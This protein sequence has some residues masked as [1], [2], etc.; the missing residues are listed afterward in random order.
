MCP[1]A[2]KRWESALNAKLIGVLKRLGKMDEMEHLNLRTN[3]RARK[4]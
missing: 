1:I 2:P 3:A 4:I